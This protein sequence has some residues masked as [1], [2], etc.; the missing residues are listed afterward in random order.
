[1][2]ISLLLILY[3]YIYIY[4][5]I[6]MSIKGKKIL[7]IGGTG[8]LGN[9]LT[10]RYMNGNNLYL[11]SRDE[12][13]HWNMNLKFNNYTFAEVMYVWIVKINYRFI[14]FNIF[15]A[16]YF[17]VTNAFVFKSALYLKQEILKIRYVF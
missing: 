16:R 3:L 15:K 2:L 10:E 11:Y 13:K 7:I 5:Y 14:F 9:K 1:M 12:S 8:S 4:I 17:N 6:Y